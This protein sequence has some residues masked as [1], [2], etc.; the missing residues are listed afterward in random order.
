MSVMVSRSQRAERLIVG[1][2]TAYGSSDF[3]VDERLRVEE[4]WQRS[5]KAV[6]KATIA[7]RLDDT[8]D[9]EE[10]RRRYHPDRRIVVMTE[11]PDPACR[12]FL[13][14]GYSPVQVSRWDGRI[15]RDGEWYV[16]E[17][18]HVFERLSRASESL[19]YGRYV[20]NGVIEDGLQSDPDAYADK[21]VLMTALPCTFNPDGVPNRAQVPL[22]VSTPNDGSRFIHLFSWDDSSAAKWTYATVLR[23]LVWFYRIKEG[24]VFEGN[25]FEVT[26]ALATGSAIAGDPL[27]EALAREPVS[28]TCEAT[29]LVEALS[30]LASAAGIHI[31]AE[32]S[33]SGGRPVTT[34][35][36]W[37]SR[38][39]SLRRLYLARGDCTSQGDLWYDA[40]EHSVSEVLS[41][42]NTY[43][44]EVAWDHRGIVNYP[45]VMGDVK[46]YEMTMP[47]CPGWE[48]TTNLDN[49]DEVDRAAAKALSLTPTQVKALG[50]AAATNDWYSKY[51]SQGSDFADYADVARL[52][53][54][55]EDGAFS[56]TTYNR[57][58]PFDDYQ[59]FDFSTVADATATGSDAW[60][61]RARRLLNTLSI[62][63][64]GRSLGV[65][66]E[67]S[68]DSGATWQ[69]ISSKV[70]VLSD[71]VGIYFDYDNPTEITP[72]DLDSEDQNMWYAIVDQTYRVRV[73]GLI[74]SDERVMGTFLP[75]YLKS[76]TLQI[77]AMM[78]RRP[79]SFRYETRSHT[80]NVLVSD[81]AF[82][83]VERD[84]TEAIA[85]LARQLAEINQDREVRVL[86]MIPWIE[87]GYAIGDR[88]A[89]VRGRHLRFATTMGSQTEY[90]AVIERRFVLQDSRYE[91]VLTLGVTEVPVGAM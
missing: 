81:E 11:D 26:D 17:A 41:A 63:K 65:W 30:L 83:G 40:S 77:N 72:V 22:T 54:L 9:S 1:V 37:S 39:G 46:R 76:P 20:R 89:E 21:S 53:V 38:S 8:F 62:S 19:V 71:R 58:A 31:T 73:T 5:D 79:K 70:R 35:R 3:Q 84:D 15:G 74:E 24:P 80:T 66:A 55:N 32:T 33:N 88:I 23:Y 75:G 87:T 85:T 10:A 2:E 44:G 45:F 36:V 64:D 47:L 78:V 4:V 68:F 60:M 28:L 91:T 52:W 90:P 61:R 16:F 34:L 82:D 49:V 56:G 29:N 18:E 13:F 48:P 42:N 7:V 43:R 67:V 50:D 69:P 25:V 14:E 51:H 57:N 59:P 27:S 6:S 86:P 12:A